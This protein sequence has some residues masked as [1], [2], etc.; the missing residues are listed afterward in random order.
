MTSGS[1]IHFKGMR[2]SH[3]NGHWISMCFF[4]FF[5]AFLR[6]CWE[7]T[8]EWTKPNAVKFGIVKNLNVRQ[9]LQFWFYCLY[10]KQIILCGYLF[11]VILSCYHYWFTINVNKTSTNAFNF[12]FLIFFVCVQDRRIFKKC[13]RFNLY[14][15]FFLFYAAKD[16][17]FFLFSPWFYCIFNYFDFAV[18]MTRITW[19]E[20]ENKKFELFKF[21]SKI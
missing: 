15:H 13:L 1:N 16:V 4:F 8:D 21:V 3:K 2:W 5:Y 11:F 6:P 9:N 20:M 14:L 17:F 19:V 12:C 18:G 10:L 7:N